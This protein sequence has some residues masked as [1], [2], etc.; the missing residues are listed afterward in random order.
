[1]KLW[2]PKCP[3]SNGSEPN[4][5][6][7][8]VER[9][10]RTHTYTYPHMPKASL[11]CNPHRNTQFSALHHLF[12]L[13]QQAAGSCY[14]QHGNMMLILILGALQPD[15]SYTIPCSL[16]KGH[17]MLYSHLYWRLTRSVAFHIRRPPLLLAPS[18]L[19]SFFFCVKAWKHLYITEQ[20]YRDC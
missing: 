14:L 6:N 7:A 9:H 18:A 3:H 11:Q 8:T 13:Q 19:C 20:S 2:G 10:V 12:P 5:V 15:R 16:V 1:M 4:C 17:C